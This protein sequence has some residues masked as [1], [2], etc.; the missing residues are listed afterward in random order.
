[1]KLNVEFINAFTDTLFKGN[2]AAVIGLYDWLSDVTLQSIATENNLSETAFYIK[3]GNTY[4]IRWFSILKEIDFCGHATLATAFSLFSKNP[5]TKVL[6]FFAESVGAFTVRTKN[7]MI[8]MEFP[9]QEPTIVRNIPEN[10]L[11]GLSI[12]PSKVLK[13]KQAYFAIYD[14]QQQVID[15]E[16]NEQLIKSLSP[17]DVVVSSIGNEYDFISRYFWPANGSL[18]DPVTGSI[19]TGLAPFWAKQL[20]RTTLTAYQASLRGG[21]LYCQVNQTHILVSGS[22][23]LYLTGQINI[24]SEHSKLRQSND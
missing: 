16:I 17:L 6:N 24:N 18:E 1:M 5:N 15:V 4:H 11:A 13:N 23:V 20:N 19:H 22:A 21:V 14:N 9:N 7:S 2:P 12:K 8:M 3:T 10:L